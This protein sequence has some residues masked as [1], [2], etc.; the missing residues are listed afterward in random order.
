MTTV[1]LAEL[2][3]ARDEGIA[4]MRTRAKHRPFARAYARLR[5]IPLAPTRRALA[6]VVL[7]IATFA[8][9]HALV[10]AGCSA[11]VTAAAMISPIAGWITT[12]L[13]L[14]FLEARRR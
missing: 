6:F 3:Q 12:G 2:F 10:L 9:R 14:F 13:A 7:H 5:A 1:S 11:F 4:S 8:S